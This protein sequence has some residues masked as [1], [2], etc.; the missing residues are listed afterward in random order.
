MADKDKEH[1]NL[2][3][4]SPVPSDAELFA[5]NVQKDYTAQEIFAGD[6]SLYQTLTQ[7]PQPGAKMPESRIAQT[8]RQVGPRLSGLT[9]SRFSLLQKTLASA[10]LLVAIVLACA[11]FKSPRRSAAEITLPPPAPMH[12]QSPSAVPANEP[13]Q[14]TELVSDTPN[15]AEPDGTLEPEPQTLSP[16]TPLSL[17]T[18][19]DM[20][21]AGEYRRAYEVYHQI[22]LYLQPRDSE[23]AFYDYLTLHKGLCLS[24]NE[25]FIEARR[26][27]TWATKSQVP[28]IRV[29]ANY[30]LSVLELSQNQFM[31]ARSRAC[32]ALALMDS[33]TDQ[34]PEWLVEL[35]QTCCYIVAEATSKQALILCNADQQLPADLSPTLPLVKMPWRRA[36]EAQIHRALAKESTVLPAILLSPSFSNDAKKPQ[37]PW[38]VACHRM[39]VD[40]LI[41]RIGAINSMEV[42]WHEEASFPALRQQAVSLHVENVSDQT[43]ISLAAGSAG[44]L[45]QVDSNGVIH[46]RNPVTA[47]LV[48]EQIAMLAQEG[49]T[50]WQRYLFLNTESPYFATAHF[51]SGRLYRQLSLKVEALSEFK[52]VASRYSRSNL[53]PYA[54]LYSSQVKEELRDALGVE[55]DLKMLVEQ[56]PNVPIVTEAFLRLANTIAQLGDDE[57]AAKLYRKV[58]YLNL[59][60]ESRVA[61]ALN[62]G[63]C[64]YRTK[65]YDSAE[66][67]LTQYIQMSQGSHA[68]EI[69]PAYFTLGQSL[70]ALGKHEM[71]CLAFHNALKGELSKEDYM[72]T[73]ASL[74]EGY[75]KQQ[76]LMEAIDVLQ[77]AFNAQLAPSDLLELDLLQSKALRGAGLLDRSIALL[78]N[79]K[80]SVSDPYLNA[81]LSYELSLSFI[82]KGQLEKAQKELS[83]ALIKVESGPL[84]HKVALT[85]AQV[86]LDLKQEDQ[87]V[88]VCR[89]VLKLDPDPILLQQ[90]AELLAKAYTIQ[91]DYDK[92]AQALIGQ[93]N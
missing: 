40:E 62:A 89:G 32:A 93:W 22:Q 28:S 36:T 6:D 55:E 25:E 82:E 49:I 30:Y 13:A 67:W 84:A 21:E 88:S 63:Q 18:A 34:D 41:A 39:A 3:P 44:L 51:T 73:M 47:A 92:A 33:L 19:Q 70:L 69:Y 26:S 52:L 23:K 65:E 83:S 46:V 42:I 8:L 5:G 91:Q 71:A 11:I 66:L 72:Q 81:K 24:L 86:C 50:M 7:T 31:P 20:F 87:A 58:F 45:A 48:S 56:Y 35:K 29:M 12:V 1:D 90:A 59:S 68:K 85:L 80:G 61:A 14:Q 38:S 16:D 75:M 43:V 2:E 54:L 74:V 37:I 79:N 15:V 77:D 27:L 78:Q 4:K 57:E 76:D 60:E 9:G 10:I 53:A 17:K 64:F